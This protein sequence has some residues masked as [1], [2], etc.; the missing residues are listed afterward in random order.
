MS[1]SS[2]ELLEKSRIISE[3]KSF[4]RNE[5]GL[6]VQRINNILEGFN[7]M[8][9]EKRNLVE[10]S[11]KAPIVVKNLVSLYLKEKEE[12]RIL[13]EEKVEKFDPKKVA[14][15]Y[16]EIKGI[17]EKAPEFS[18]NYSIRISPSLK[19]SKRSSDLIGINTLVAKF[20]LR[21]TNNIIENALLS[22]VDSDLK[23]EKSNYTISFFKSVK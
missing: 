12:K 19:S 15:S 3:L 10:L 7:S 17:S 8:V 14:R 9:K 23:Y 22:E 1:I 18:R 6:N 21:Y 13:K 2:Y 4:M 11:T 5:Q 20:G 16:K